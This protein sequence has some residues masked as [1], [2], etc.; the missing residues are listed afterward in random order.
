MKNI[1]YFIGASLLT[2]CATQAEFKGTIA[3]I[4]DDIE[5]KMTG[6]SWKPECPVPLE[7]LR[8]LTVNHWDYDD[9]EQTGHLVVHA[10]LAD[11]LLAIFHE[12]Y[13][14]HFPIE[15]MELID[16]YN[17]DDERSMAANNSS[18]FCCRS[19]TNVPGK[20]S[21]HSYGI[22]IDINPIVNPY[23]KGTQVLPEGGRA[24]LDR[25][26]PHQGIITKSLDNAC[27][28]IF[29]QYGYEWGGDWE[30]RVDYQHFQ[31]PISAVVE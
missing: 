23:V 28:R 29:T 19:I 21:L 31:K 3:K 26:K 27:Y 17:A 4:P 24:Y 2:T 6:C 20:F 8:Y 5:K 16:F 14:A 25:T 1:F 18:A 10:K 7:N 15:R 22:A 11:E 30:T 12:L 13:D 9:K